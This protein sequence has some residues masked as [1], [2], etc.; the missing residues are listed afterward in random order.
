M[1]G[2]CLQKTLEN[3]FVGLKGYMTK[4]NTC[5]SATVPCLVPE[6]VYGRL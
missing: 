5:L 1:V 3:T 4:S 6:N 2:L